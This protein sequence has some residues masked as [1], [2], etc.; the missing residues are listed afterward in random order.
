MQD[1]QLQVSC[2]LALKVLSSKQ[3]T[4]CKQIRLFAVVVDCFT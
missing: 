4:A 2:K 1:F 3:M